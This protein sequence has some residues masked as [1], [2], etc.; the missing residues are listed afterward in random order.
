MTKLDFTSQLS[1]NLGVD[2]RQIGSLSVPTATAANPLAQQ[3]APLLVLRRG[4]G[5]V[6]C[7]VSGVRSGD[8]TGSTV[9]QS[10]AQEIDIANVHGT[11]IICPALSPTMD[12]QNSANANANPLLEEFAAQ[13]LPAADVIVEICSASASTSS[14]PH[15]AVWPGVDNETNQLAEELMIAFGAPDSVRRFDAPVEASL[16][17]VAEQLKTPFFQ[18]D[19]GHYASTDRAARLMGLSGCRN[20]LLHI[21]LLKDGYFDLSSTRMLEIS[22][23]LCR[24]ATP[25]R[26]LV[27]WHA[28]LGGSVHLGNPMAEIFD[29]HRPF[30]KPIA[31][32][33]PMNGVLLCKQSSAL[34]TSHH[35]LAVIGDEVPR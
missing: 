21:K 29:P 35:C 8:V 5:P 13:I 19:L 25:I 4:E 16:A 33:A 7:L 11:L 20:L 14:A 18:V 1:V 15:A 23:P 26:G 17:A 3:A 12:S 10:L 9:L 28:D 31:I 27:Q 24:V 22:K 6:V 30:A 2:G 32:N 34:V